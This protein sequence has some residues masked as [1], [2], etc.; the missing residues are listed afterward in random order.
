MGTESVSLVLVK[1][2]RFPWQMLDEGPAGLY[3]KEKQ[4]GK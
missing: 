1:M 4:N 2:A 3:H